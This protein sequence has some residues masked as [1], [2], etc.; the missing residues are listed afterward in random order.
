MKI[1]VLE[2]YFGGSHE[3]FIKGLDR[4][5]PADLELLTLPAR[6]WKWRMRLAAPLFAEQLQAPE[7]V[8]V[9]F[10]LPARVGDAIFAFRYDRVIP[11]TEV[12]RWVRP[13]PMNPNLGPMAQILGIIA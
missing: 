10:D 8:D 9:V 4:H 5:I 12:I 13:T 6:K 7:N 1:L 11:D 3:S 2:P